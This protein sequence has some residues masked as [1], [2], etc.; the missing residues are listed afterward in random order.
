MTVQQK[1][2]IRKTLSLVAL[3]FAVTFGVAMLV[4]NMSFEDQTGSQLIQPSP[5][6]LSPDIDMEWRYTKDGWRHIGEM[7]PDRFA[8]V[9]TFE[10]IHPFVWAAT[11]MMAVV[12]TT[13]WASSEW[14]IARLW[15]E[16]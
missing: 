9:R 5:P 2:T 14:E 12:G 7:Y 8:P 4:G 6:A 3:S 1:Q 11:V 16:E 10:S 15:K 13:V